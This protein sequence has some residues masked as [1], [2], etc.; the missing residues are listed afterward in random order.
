[1]TTNQIGFG[2]T[3][4]QILAAVR[5]LQ[6]TNTTPITVLM[7]VEHLIPGYA[8]EL[9]ATGGTDIATYP[10][11]HNVIAAAGRN[12]TLAVDEDEHGNLLILTPTTV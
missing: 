7:V 8:A 9:A 1:M 4:D 11:V 3:T 10:S 12:G 2:P 5:S 6:A